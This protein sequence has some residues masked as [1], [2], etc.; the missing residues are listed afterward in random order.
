MYKRILVTLD[1][2]KHAEEVLPHVRALANCTGAEVVLL[3]VIVYPH[4]DFIVG[5]PMIAEA[6]HDAAQAEAKEYMEQA[7]ANLSKTG[8]EVKGEVAEGL[9][10][11]TIIDFAEKVQADLIAMSTHGRSGPARWLVGSVADKVVRGATVPVLL[12]RPIAKR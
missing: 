8:L 3:R 1:G 4:Y 7:V 9:V 2:S 10:A 12:V 11:D 6:A 5:D